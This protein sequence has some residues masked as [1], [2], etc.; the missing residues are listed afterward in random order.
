MDLTNNVIF[1]RSIDQDTKNALLQKSDIF[2]MPSI[3]DANQLKDLEFP[4]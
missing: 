1:L 2:L 3:E 4:F